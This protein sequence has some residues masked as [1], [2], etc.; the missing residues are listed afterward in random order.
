MRMSP[1]QNIDD[2]FQS[3]EAVAAGYQNTTFA[4]IAIKHQSDFVLVQGRIFFNT[5]PSRIPHSHF[6]SKSVRAGHYRLAEFKMDARALIGCLCSGTLETPHGPLRFPVSHEGSYTANYTPLHPDGLR[7]QARIS[8]LRIVGGTPDFSKQPALDWELKAAAV[9]YDSLQELAFEYALAPSPDVTII[10]VEAIAF[11][12]AGIDATKS[13]VSGVNATVHVLLA[14]GLSPGLIKLGYRIPGATP[15]RASITGA[16]MEWTEEDHH[17]RGIAL[18]PV[19][20]ASVV[21]CTV[22]YNEI[23]QNHWW[24][25]DPTRLQNSRRAVLEAFDN[26]LEALTDIL[27]KAL[28]RGDDARNLETGV[29]WLLWMLGFSVAQLGATPRTRD[30]ADLIATTPRGDFAVIECTTGLL[31]EESKLGLLYAR[32]QTVRRALDASGHGHLRVLPVI[33]TSKSREDVKA[34]IEQAERVGILV[35]TREDLEEA[36]NRTLTFP[37]ADELYE[38]AIQAASSAQAKYEAQPTLPLPAP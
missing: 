4:Y 18:F 8:V 10:N 24:L 6:Q 15:V 29:G 5:E 9:P 38:Q 30:A 36:L 7:R 32:T 33:V 20:N 26:Q 13:S 28:R 2:F 21:N 25:G 16:K 31:R 22:S 14:K 37:M 11:N 23:A 35:R 12:V 3:I 34:E 1:Q 17:Q 27:T 19:P